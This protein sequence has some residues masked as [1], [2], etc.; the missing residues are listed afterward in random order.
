VK[1]VGSTFA[2]NMPHREYNSEGTAMLTTGS[3]AC[4]HLEDQRGQHRQCG[5]NRRAAA[6]ITPPNVCKVITPSAYTM[7]TTR[8]VRRQASI[9]KRYRMPITSTSGQ[10]RFDIYGSLFVP[11]CYRHE[12]ARECQTSLYAEF[13]VEMRPT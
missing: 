8:V 1:I 6:T 3:H 12:W 7:F 11:T 10:I 9:W 2:R 5:S 13:E 4:S